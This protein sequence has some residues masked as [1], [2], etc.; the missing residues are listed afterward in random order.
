MKIHRTAGPARFLRPSPLLVFTLL[1][2][3]A[4]G[5]DDADQPSGL[6]LQSPG[7]A[8]FGGLGQTTRFS[9]EFNPAIGFVIDAFTDYVDNDEQ[10]GFDAELRLVELNAATYIDPDTWGYVVFSSEG[11]EAPEVEEAAVVY[12]GFEGTTTV[13]AGRFFLD[14]GKQMQW[15]PEEWRT[16]ERP[17]VLREFLGEELAGTGVSVGH[18][19]PV[20]ET[21]VVRF[22]A[23][24]FASLLGEGHHGEEE[25]EGEGAESSVPD[26]RDFDEFSFAARATGM[27]DVGENGQIQL[28][29]S[30]RLVPEFGFE[31]EGLEE[32]GLSN[33][34][35]G[36]DAT[37]GRTDDTGQQSL[38]LG[39]EFLV[40]D[41]DL[42][43]S[44]DDSGVSP[45]LD[46]VDDSVTGAMLYAD[47]GW[48]GRNSAGLQYSFIDSPEDPDVAVSEVDV[49]FTRLLTELRRIRV[50]ATFADSDEFGEE[51]RAYV[52]FTAILGSHSH[53]LDW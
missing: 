48:N 10:D 42:S 19:L 18:W 30:G 51:V 36:F 34:V 38:L 44:V 26:R 45:T 46:V 52:Q 2:T 3:P 28:G 20:G 25:E 35:Y 33:T 12:S 31:A 1:A 47:Y 13:K 8:Q 9:S 16:L 17:L 23:G 32:G 11:G 4:F 50:G 7:Q 22:S 53:G 21:S 24:A 41:G 39:G 40:L 29:V 37:Y 6:L 14:F 5:Q 27:T 49:Y 15:H 43:A